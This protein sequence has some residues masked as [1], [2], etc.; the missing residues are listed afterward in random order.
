MRSNSL[1]TLAVWGA[2]KVLAAILVLWGASL[3]G[4]VVLRS[5]PGP[6]PGALESLRM[7]PTA[8]G[9]P[10]P[11]APGYGS[12]LRHALRAD[13]GRSTRIQQGRP[14]VHLLAAAARRS[15]CLAGAAMLMAAL[16]AMALAWARLT[17]PQ[18]RLLRI[19]SGLVHLSS[20]L[21]VFLLV[22]IAVI[23]GN[24]VL[25]AGA[26][27]G[28]WS[29]P[30][31]FPFPSRDHWIPWTA[32]AAVL[33]LGDGLLADM[34]RRF[35]AELERTRANDYWIGARLLG[36]ALHRLLFRAALPGLAAYLSRRTAFVLGSTVVLES[37]LGWP[38]LG[39]LAW[40]AAAERDTPVL[41]GCA[42]VMALVVRV[43]AVAADA[44]RYWADPR[45][46][47]HP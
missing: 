25:S 29:L 5:A 19:V 13:L 44:F 16:S 9:A 23:L 14:V 27:Q 36:V 1:R 46:R 31:W 45:L 42:L 10:E 2:R 11:H 22:Y 30:P 12:W 4:Y 41:L 40:R 18:V 32:A 3:L 28:L 35:S 24:R 15:L 37:A 7:T 26:E 17:F 38:G 47:G 34:Y 8:P 6:G 43:T 21:P 33:A 39:Y 20:A